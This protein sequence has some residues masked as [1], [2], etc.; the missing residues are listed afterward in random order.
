M[1]NG[2]WAAIF[3]GGYNNTIDND[4]DA[5]QA[6]DSVTGNAILYVVDIEDGSL[7]KK[8]DTQVGMMED[9]TGQER[10]NGLT[11]PTVIDEDGDFISDTIYVGDLFGNVWKI[12]ISDK[13]TVHWD[14]AYRSGLSPQPFYTACA[15]TFCT[16][17]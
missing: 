17:H 14:F 12:D 10:P 4:H 6:N 11:T 7:I 1:Q 8:F 3:S 15:S 5:D 16:A 2:K 13:L 9:P